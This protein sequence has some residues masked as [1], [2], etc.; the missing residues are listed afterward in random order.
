MSGMFRPEPDDEIARRRFT[1][2]ALLLGVGQAAAFGV[3]KNQL[4]KV[5][6]LSE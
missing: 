2:R 6:Y 4:A 1:R 5:M 3:I